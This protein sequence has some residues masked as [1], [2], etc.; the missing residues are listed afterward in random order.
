MGAPPTSFS[1]FYRQTRPEVVRVARARLVDPA[2]AEDVAQEALQVIWSRW[3]EVATRESPRHWTLRVALNLAATRNRRQVGLRE[4]LPLLVAGAVHLDHPRDPDTA[5]WR[6]VAGL[7]KKQADAVVLRLV[8]DASYEDLAATL[9]CSV[10][11]AR[12]HVHRGLTQIRS[13]YLVHV[14]GVVGAIEE[15]YV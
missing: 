10:V 1:V 6:I 12:Q 7:P 8:L 13:A 2:D 5:L 15:G 3:A 11:S 14:R 9:G 4:R